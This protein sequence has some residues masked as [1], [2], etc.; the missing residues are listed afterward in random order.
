MSEADEMRA[1]ASMLALHSM[2][3]FLVSRAVVAQPEIGDALK[4]HVE[5]SMSGLV[6]RNPDLA[7][8]AQAACGVVARALDGR[9]RFAVAQ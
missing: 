1:A 6:R 8:A 7:D 2:V 5:I 3:E 4:A 9:P